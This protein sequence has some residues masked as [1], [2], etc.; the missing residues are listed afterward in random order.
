VAADAAM[1]THVFGV[2]GFLLGQ[3]Q[4]AQIQDLRRED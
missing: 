1:Q 2:R 4:A 3:Q